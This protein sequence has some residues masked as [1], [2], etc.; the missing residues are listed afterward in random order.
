V[1]RSRDATIGLT[2]GDRPSRGCDE[3]G[4]VDRGIGVGAEIE[5]L[6]SGVNKTSLE[7]LFEIEPPVVGSH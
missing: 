2:G 7:V 5:H 1:R 4:E 6:V 3:V